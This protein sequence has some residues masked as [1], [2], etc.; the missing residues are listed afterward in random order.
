MD[1]LADG[2]DLAPNH[3]QDEGHHDR[4]GQDTLAE[5]QVVVKG[6]GGKG[7]WANQFGEAL[8]HLLIRRGGR[9]M[10]AAIPLDGPCMADRTG[11]LGL[12]RCWIIFGHRLS[13]VRIA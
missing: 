7:R 2:S 1:Q 4:Q 13:R 8:G 9:G 3:G 6:D 11:F 5:A 10:L 12:F